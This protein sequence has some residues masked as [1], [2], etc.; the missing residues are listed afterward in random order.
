MGAR[1]LGPDIAACRQSAI[2][3]IPVFEIWANADASEY[4]VKISC[5]PDFVMKTDARVQYDHII[6][7]APFLA[8]NLEGLSKKLDLIVSRHSRA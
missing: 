7:A 2:S 8:E 4:A 3:K 1:G 5:I 6:Y